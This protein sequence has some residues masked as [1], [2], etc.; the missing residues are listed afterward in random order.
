MLPTATGGDRTHRGDAV[1]DGAAAAH[2]AVRGVRRTSSSRRC[3]TRVKMSAAR[4]PAGAV[5]RA[6]RRQH[7]GGAGRARL[8][9]E[10]RGREAARARTAYQLSVVAG[11]RRR[12]RPLP[13]L[14]RGAPPGDRAGGRAAR[15][16][17][18]APRCRLRGHPDAC[19]RALVAARRDPAPQARSAGRSL[20]AARPRSRRSRRARRRGRRP[21][22]R[23]TTAARSARRCSTSPRTA[24]RLVGVEREVAVRRRHRSI[25]RAAARCAGRAGAG[26]A[27]AG[28]SRGDTRAHGLHDRHAATPTSTSAR[29]VA[30]EASG[31]LARRA[32]DRLRDRRRPDRQPAG[33]HA[34]CRS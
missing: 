29:E 8:H 33:D 23:P 32:A 27:A 2:R 1:G 7:A 9:L 6:G 17:A 34:A 14:A 10:P 3:G 21:T 4:H 16:S 24:T 11:A 26:A 31:R 30:S 12:R 20:V 5:P 18:R 19:A 28:D 25:R 15:P 13:R 22:R